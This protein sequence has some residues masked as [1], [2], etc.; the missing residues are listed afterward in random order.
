MSNKNSASNLIACN[1]CTYVRV[2]E[3]NVNSFG[4]MIGTNFKEVQ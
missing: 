3:M 1:T 4:N 2:A